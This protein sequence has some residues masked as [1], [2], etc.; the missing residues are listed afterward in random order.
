M[1]LSLLFMNSNNQNASAAC[2]TPPHT[3]THTQKT[4]SSLFLSTVS[5]ISY[6]SQILPNTNLVSKNIVLSVFSVRTGLFEPAHTLTH[7]HRAYENLCRGLSHHCPLCINTL[8]QTGACTAAP[9]NRLLSLMYRLPPTTHISACKLITAVKT[10]P[11]SYTNRS[12]SSLSVHKQAANTHF[13]QS[14]Q[15]FRL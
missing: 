9:S 6:S 3:N 4:P 1:F 14:W 10:K 2:N 11:S 8:A 7:S 12:S 15:T 5:E 13:V